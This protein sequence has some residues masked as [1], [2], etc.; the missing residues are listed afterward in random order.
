MAEV[1][2]LR[3]GPISTKEPDEDVLAALETYFEQ[4]KSGKIRGVAFAFITEQ[5][6]TVTGWSGD[7][8]DRMMLSAVSLLQYRLAKCLDERD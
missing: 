1:V 8:D 2:G 5:N 4:A 7:C 6:F 3:G